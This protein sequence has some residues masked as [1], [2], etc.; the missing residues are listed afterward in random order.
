M[1]RH[2]TNVKLLL[3]MADGSTP[4][5]SESKVFLHDGT[6]MTRERWINLAHNA[7]N[8][9]APEAL[10][11]RVSEI[12]LTKTFYITID[13]TE[14]PYLT[15]LSGEQH[16]VG[17]GALSITFDTVVHPVPIDLRVY[18]DP[19][20]GIITEAAVSRFQLSGRTLH[21]VAVANED[22]TKTFKMVLDPLSES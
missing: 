4:D 19:R 14:Q 5:M 3:E 13:P 10:V 22:G 11:S 9:W 6:E 17:G 16:L 2:I 15:E 20:K 7:L 12:N 1:K 21:V 8:S 18:S